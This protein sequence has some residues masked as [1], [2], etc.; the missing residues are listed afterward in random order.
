MQRRNAAN[1]ISLRSSGK[2]LRGFTLAELIVVLAVLAIVAV[3][4]VFTA[5]AYINKAKF[6]KNNQN[7]IT[8]YQTA[9]TALTKKTASGTMDS[10]VLGIPGFD[11]NDPDLIDLSDKETNYSKH[12]TIALTYNKQTPDHNEDGY[13][14]ELLT[15]YFY[16]Q[17]VFNATMTV[18]L[19]ICA[20]M[21]KDSK[22]VSYSANVI[23]AFYS[24]ENG[25]PSSFSTDT[26]DPVKSGGWDSTCTNKGSTSDGL[27]VRDPDYRAKTSYVGYYDGNSDEVALGNISA[28]VIPWD[29]TFE[30]QGHIIGPTEDN[31]QAHGYLF[32]LRNGE[33]LDVSWAVF[34]ADRDMERDAETGYNYHYEAR[35]DHNDSIHMKL[36]DENNKNNITDIF[37]SHDQFNAASFDTSHVFRS[38]EDYDNYSIVRESVRGFVKADVQINNGTRTTMSFPFTRSLVKGDIR[39]GCPV[40]TDEGYYEYSLT[41]DA[42]M[43]RGSGVDTPADVK[44]Y[45]GIE[46][47]F[48][49]KTPR[50]IHAVLCSD[51]SWS[52]YDNNGALKTVNGLVNT[53]AARAINDPVYLHSANKS[54]D[55]ISYAYLVRE[56]SAKFDG[57]DDNELYDDYVVTGIAVVNTYFGDK[58]Y[59]SDPAITDNSKYIGGTTWSADQGNAVLTNCRHLYN[60]RWFTSGENCYRIVSNINW[61][62]H[63]GDKFSSEVK[64]FSKNDG[65]TNPNSPVGSDGTLLTVSFPAINKLPS[66]SILT[67]ISDSD[68]KIYRINGI[69]L[70]AGSFKNGTD[71]GYGLFCENYGNIYN[72]YLNNIS[73]IMATVNDGSTCDYAG[74]NTNFTPTGNV[75]VTHADGT[76]DNYPAG[77]LVGHNKG[78]I[79]SVSETDESVNTVQVTNSVVMTGNYWKTSKIGDAGLVIGKN[80]GKNGGADSSYG[81]IKAGGRFVVIGNRNAGGII[82]YNNSDIKARL[83]VDG[84]NNQD[85][86]F[87]FPKMAVTGETVSCA[88]ISLNKAGGAIGQFDGGFKFDLDIDHYSVSDPDQNTGE[89]VFDDPSAGNFN[90]SVTLPEDSLV[91]HQTGTSDPSAGGAIGFLNTSSGDYL[92]IYTNVSGYIVSSSNGSPYCGGAIGREINCSIK[93]IYL[94]CNNKEGS[95]IG[96]VSTTN[97]AVCAGGAYGRIETNTLNLGTSRTIAVN[98]YND[99]TISSRGTANGFGAGGAIGGA[100]QL[101]IPVKIRAY[102]DENSRII[103]TGDNVT[104]CNG[105]GGAVGGIGNSTITEDKSVLVAGS[106]VFAENHGVISG[107][108]HVG[109]TFGNGPL[110]RGGIYAVNYG[111]ITGSDFV[112]GAIGRTIKEQSGTIQSILSGAEISGQNFVGGA[113]GR[114]LYFQNGAYIRTRVWDSSTISGSNQLVGGVCG[115]ILI[116][117]KN[118]YGTIELKGNNTNPTLI[119]KGG[120]GNANAVGTG[121]IAGALRTQTA[122][123]VEVISPSQSDL[124]RLAI[125]VDGRYDVGGVVG[126]LLTNG[127]SSN[128]VSDCISSSQSVNFTYEFD[129]KLHPQSH[130]YGSG[131]NVGGAIGN[132]LSSGGYFTGKVNVASVYGNSSDE[133]YIRGNKN[134]GGAVGCISKSLPVYKNGD[135]EIHVNFTSSPWTIEGTAGSGDANVGGAVGYISANRV[136]STAPGYYDFYVRMGASTVTSSGNNVGGAIGFNESSLRES[137]LEVQLDADGSVSGNENV[138]G[139]IGKNSL[140]NDYGIVNRVE[141]TINGEVHGSGKNVGG[142]IGYNLSKVDYVTAVINGTVNGEGDRVG[143]AIGYSDATNASYLVKSVDAAIQGSGKVTGNNYVGGAVGMSVCNTEDITAKIAGNAK[144]QGVEGVG[145]AL[146]FASAEKG[147]TGGNVLAGSNY[148]RILR[149]KVNISADYALSGKTRMGGAVGQIGAKVDGSNYNSP[150]LVY[151]EA[152]LNSAYLFDPYNTGTDDDASD[153]NA[154]I[155]GIIGIFVDGRLGVSSTKPVQNGGVVLKGSGGVVN[156]EEFVDTEFFP[157]RT[158]GNTVFIGANGCS[159]GGI[160]GQIGYD[161]M[162]QNVCLSNISVEDGPDLCVVSLNGKDRIGGWIGSGYAAHGGIGNNNADEFD[163]TPVTYNVDNVRAV[164]SIGGSEVGGFC[165]RS[166]AYNNYASTNQIYTF[167]NINVDLIDANI[168]GSSKVGGAFGETYCLN[169]LNSNNKTGSI[170]VN[171]SSYTNIGDV[172]GNALPGDNNTYTPI[173]YEAGGAIGCIDSNYTAGK[174]RVNTFLIPITVTIDSTSRVCGLA[175]PADNAS[176]Y[177]V[178]GAFGYSNCDFKNDDKHKVQSVTVIS[179][180]GS[181]P[182]VISGYANAGGVVGI[183]DRGNLR[184]ASTNVTVSSTASNAGVGGVVGKTINST[185]TNTITIE[186]CHFGPDAKITAD[187]YFSSIK[188]FGTDA[189]YDPASYRVVSEGSSAYAGGFAGT[190]ESDVTMSNCYTTATVDAENSGSAGGFIGRANKGKVNNCYAGGHTYSRHY[191]SNSANVTGASNV[192]GFIGQTT[193]A[194]AIEACY[195]TASVYGSGSNVGGFA[196]YFTGKTTVKT[197]YCTGLVTCNDAATTGSFVGRTENTTYTDSCSMNGINMYKPLAGNAENVAGLFSRNA[198]E[199]RGANN[200]AAHPFDGS[201]GTTYELRAVINKEHWGDWPEADDE[202]M[203]IAQTTIVLEPL[204]YEY[205][206]S[207]YHLEEHL[208]ITD[209][210][211]DEPVELEYGVDYQLEYANISGI[212]KNAQVIITGIGNYYGAVSQTF[213]ITKASIINASVVISYPAGSEGGFEYTGA[214]KVPVSVVTLGEDVLTEGIDYYL[215]YDPDNINITD[216]EHPVK[217]SVVG[218][219]NYEGRIDNA[220]TFMIIGRNL[221]AAE[222][223]LLTTE[224]QLVYDGN[225]KRPD[226]TV[227]IDGKT[228]VKG[229]DYNVEYLNNIDAGT[230]TVR[231]VPAEGSNQ[232]TGHKD[233]DFTITQATNL[234]KIEPGIAGW[235][236]NSTPSELSPELQ[237]EFGTPLYSVHT[238][239]ACTD[240]DKVLGD[241]EAAE[242]QEAMRSLDAGSYY[243]LA[244]IEETG[245]YTG[246]SKIVPFTVARW[247]ISGNVTV[248]LQYIRT[249]YNGQSQKP[250]V[251]VKYNGKEILDSANYVVNYGNDTTSVGTKTVTVTGTKNC[252]G[253]ATAQ[254]EIAAVWTVNFHPDPG[255]MDAREMSAT[256]TD[257]DKVGRPENDPVYDGY[258]FDGWYWY[259]NPSSFVPFDF[260]SKVTSDLNIYAKWTQWRYVTLVF[261]NGDDDQII[262]VGNAEKMSEPEEPTREGYDFGGW[263]GDAALTNK[264]TTFNVPIEQDYTLYA[265]W[266]PQTHTATFEILEDTENMVDPQEL[267]YPAVLT[268]PE[269]PAREGYYLDGWYTDEDCTEAFEDFDKPLPEDIKLYAKWELQE[270]TVVFETSGGTAIQSLTLNYQDM[271]TEPADPQKEGMVF[272]GWYS[273]ENC[274]IPFVDFDKAIIEFEDRVSKEPVVIILYAKWKNA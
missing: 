257:G 182:A 25:L 200:D 250:E 183:I 240:A 119:V 129:V 142:C 266:I 103:G 158:Y 179:K 166:D 217:V 48:G 274:T 112:G 60:I 225:E 254:Y 68:R 273:D 73:L 244:E 267:V 223:T 20:T 82:G 146:G 47:L 99:G 11:E 84:G 12:K 161:K 94:E 118:A 252:L 253:T 65:K 241:Y 256:V 53:Y 220:G 63:S 143:G 262:S 26:A 246:V 124:N 164:I 260:N 138:G 49:D 74:G 51:S 90:I 261:N 81:L 19:D 248:E 239:A 264:W 172:A 75:T 117:D 247:N 89:P 242:L 28:V 95:L 270:Y 115:D 7:A 88:V 125:N 219:G 152:T 178:G 206:K 71:K 52:S 10:W 24:A 209:N 222:V 197:S 16:N 31:S 109:G 208:T 165:G 226:V 199:I 92:S 131:N 23:S 41:L 141:S 85:N 169:Y 215:A 29:Q 22:K 50:N 269:D 137:V 234:I 167:A 184:N 139:V 14:Y 192:G 198:S 61:Y 201:L 17:S 5:I 35:K 15:P 18:E 170:N 46:R 213:E 98:V 204:K 175:V 177:G 42:M 66:D 30:L 34:D 263:Y 39:T 191:I 205:R 69:Q 38:Y 265:K 110:N 224:E 2:R 91:L 72:V 162:Q 180:D 221:D 251:T 154:C 33:T 258:R 145:G 181:V 58:V 106:V 107:V 236:W 144:V 56:H 123:A 76:N 156:T 83:V 190:L 40:D 86:E 186:N 233:L 59:G 36:C 255:T 210:N 134:V 150:A 149:V 116:N 1:L 32:N 127:S 202:R 163:K 57:E 195:S 67:S 54:G 231:I 4:G 174:T 187:G 271:I 268:R 133:S 207:G 173:C 238:S 122:D 100:V 104:N 111:T 27:P 79:G 218:F 126:R 259:P 168:I 230:A 176:N 229:R 151:V 102:N 237:A 3:A 77:S 62:V 64:V 6:D 101:A 128:K 203:N 120:T 21:N 121:G 93:D 113:A 132:V 55:H 140:P 43:S 228:L 193:G 130:I 160:V 232:Y 212:G 70:R 157:A 155:G 216:E 159:I 97:G 87:S 188:I 214:P 272:D 148:G 211:G 45:Y 44:T 105:T 147:K 235:T 153:S 136:T 245:N 135:S 37:I 227:R 8:V 13:L 171:L 185:S 80:E 78:V 96:C 114:L 9:Q 108:H 243:L 189:V 249:P 194:L 196:G